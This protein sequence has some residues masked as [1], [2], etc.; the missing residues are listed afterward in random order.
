MT[1]TNFEQNNLFERY[2]KNTHF[3]LD[4]RG[5]SAVQTGHIRCIHVDQGLQPTE[6]QFQAPLMFFFFFFFLLSLLYG[7]NNTFCE[8]STHNIK[9]NHHYTVF[10]ES[11]TQ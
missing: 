2:A 3:K 6:E 8:E 9:T 4:A 5:C 1:K 10:T 7:Q 11:V